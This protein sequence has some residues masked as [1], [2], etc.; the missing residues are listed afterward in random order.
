MRRDLTD[1]GL[2]HMGARE[3]SPAL[4]RWLTP[5]RYVGESPKLMVEKLL[6]ANL[7]A[8][9]MGNPNRFVDPTGQTLEEAIRVAR[10]LGTTL[11]VAGVP[12]ALADGI[13]AHMVIQAWY[14]ENIDPNAEADMSLFRISQSVL[15]PDGSPAVIAAIANLLLRPDLYSPSNGE[16]WE[17]K[18]ESVGAE[19]AGAE[20]AM[21][22]TALGIMGL[23]A[24]PG[25]TPFQ[26]TIRISSS[27][28]LQFRSTDSGGILYRFN[29]GQ[30]AR[31]TSEATQTQ[32]AAQGSMQDEAFFGLIGVIGAA[33]I[34]CVSGGCALP[35]LPVPAAVPL[36]VGGEPIDGA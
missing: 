5:D 15:R 26:A 12:P 20:A 4:G 21:Y 19:V 17:I 36:T 24:Y 16:V 7:Y 13:V 9:A 31:Q 23:D 25:T 8:Y 2:V 30:R 33:V 6:E 10:E 14:I 18:P 3:Y 35:P 22:A 32:S 11:E 27:V 28:E 29:R 1:M 34:W